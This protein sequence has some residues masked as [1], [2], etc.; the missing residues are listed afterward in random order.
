MS[1]FHIFTVLREGRLR[2]PL[3]LLLVEHVGVRRRGANALN[4]ILLANH[5]AAIV[6]LAA[7]WRREWLQR[8]TAGAAE[9]SLVSGSALVT[10]CT[11]HWYASTVLPLV[12]STE[13][14]LVMRTHAADVAATVL[15]NIH[16]CRRRD[17]VRAGL[18]HLIS[19]TVA[20]RTIRHRLVLDAQIHDLREETM[21]RAHGELLVVAEATLVLEVQLVCPLRVRRSEP[22]CT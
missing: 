18:L 15:Q 20:V 16:G 22:S 14:V 12:E 4:F 1:W 6:L 19:M 17:L 10:I 21:L 3:Q 5:N 9:A 11:D 13:V 8:E 7:A 2:L